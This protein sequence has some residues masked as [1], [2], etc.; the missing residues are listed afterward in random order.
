MNSFRTLALLAALTA[1]FMGLGYMFGGPGGAA[2]A[3]AA[4]A[5]MNLFTFWNADRILLSMHDAH[6]VGARDCPALT[7]IVHDLAARAGLPTPRVYIIDSPH[8]NAFPTG[9]APAPAPAPPA[10]TL[11]TPPSPRPPGCSG[12]STARKW[13]RCSP[14]SSAMSATATR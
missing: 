4:A 10:A 3:L 8:P 14:M 2:I 12:C 5:L 13:R 11:R 6:E 9:R 1:L 7:G